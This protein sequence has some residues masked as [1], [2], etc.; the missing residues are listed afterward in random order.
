[1]TETE[2]T[3]FLTLFPARQGQVGKHLRNITAEVV[4]NADYVEAKFILGRRVEEAWDALKVPYDLYRAIGSVSCLHDVISMSKKVNKG[5]LVV[6]RGIIEPLR[7]FCAIVLPIALLMKDL[8]NKTLKSHK[9]NPEVEA[10]KAAK[11][12]DAMPRATCGCC[13]KGQAVLP[14][15]YIHDHGYTLPEE[16]HKSASC[17]GRQFRPLEVSDEGP[18][19][20]VTLLENAERI[21]IAALEAAPKATRLFLHPH[22]AY[23]TVQVEVGHPAFVRLL[24]NHIENAKNN[25]S[26]IQ[27]DL[28][29]FRRVV[30][31]WKAA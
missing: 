16:W 8:K 2:I 30:A 15:G 21:S 18:K 6:D 23:D 1:M 25:L 26:R 3:V 29:A 31:E 13:F 14:N 12:E 9:P 27:K 19:Y 20:M 24:I 11:F 17:Y 7:A 22:N 28:A 5:G 10:R 4:Y